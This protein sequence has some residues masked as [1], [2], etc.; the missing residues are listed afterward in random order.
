MSV[1]V[2]VMVGVETEPEEIKGRGAV[3]RGRTCGSYLMPCST[4]VPLKCLDSAAG[5]PP[6]KAAA[7]DGLLVHTPPR[8]QSRCIRHRRPSNRYVDIIVCF[9]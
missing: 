3:I 5:R 9:I 8:F 2:V 1:E 6:S 7:A 4:Q